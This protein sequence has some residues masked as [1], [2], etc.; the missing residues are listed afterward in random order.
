MK[1]DRV[2]INKFKKSYAKDFLYHNLENKV[3]SNKQINKIQL[4]KEQFRKELQELKKS[5]KIRDSDIKFYL[6]NK[7]KVEIA[8]PTGLLRKGELSAYDVET[9]L[10]VREIYKFCLKAS[11]NSHYFN[12]NILELIKYKDRLKYFQNFFYIIYCRTKNALIF[13]VQ[14]LDNEVMERFNLYEFLI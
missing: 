14:K 12:P 7:K 10:M 1:L 5:K 2:N 11:N 4:L 8:E 6:E 13:Q 3:R 9:N